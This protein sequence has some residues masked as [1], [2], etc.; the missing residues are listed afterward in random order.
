MKLCFPLINTIKITNYILHQIHCW[1][2]NQLFYKR[3]FHL[4]PANSY[5]MFQGRCPDRN[6]SIL[7]HMTS[8]SQHQNVNKGNIVWNIYKIFIPYWEIRTGKKT[9]LVLFE[10]FANFGIAIVVDMKRRSKHRPQVYKSYTYGQ[11]FRQ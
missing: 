7:K 3:S 8:F 2:W 9:P 4:L 5:F 1:C 6:Y 11:K 10:L